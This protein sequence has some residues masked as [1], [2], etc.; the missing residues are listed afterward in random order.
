VA[1]GVGQRGG[2]AL[3][4]IQDAVVV[5]IHVA[6]V[7]QAVAVDVGQHRGITHAVVV[8]VAL[9]QRVGV[10]GI[11]DA[12]AV[13][14]AAVHV[15]FGGIRQRVVV[16]VQ[17]QVV[18]G[19]VAVGVARHAVADAGLDGVGDAVAIAVAV[20]VVGHAVVVAIYRVQRVRAGFD[21]VRD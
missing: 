14:I 9:A 6:E 19:A 18:G 17:I 16:A 8:D 1:I 2:R 15:A 4:R 5:G 13:G 20:P 3:V 12:I 11:V 10:E 21:A 7:R